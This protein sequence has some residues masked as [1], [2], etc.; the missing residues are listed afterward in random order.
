MGALGR[1]IED[2]GVPTTQISLI[3]LHTETIQPPRA[4]WVPFE[5][6]R[7]LGV[8]GDPEFQRRVL[9]S[10]LRL[11]EAPQGPVLEDYLEEAPASPD[12]PAVLSC[13]V[14]FTQDR[15]D[16]TDGEKLCSAL[17]KEMGA[18]RPWYDMALGKR[19][20]T[21]VGVSG[22]AL[23]AIPGF[24]C[25]FLG[26]DPPA[27]PLKDVKLPYALNLATD[28][29]KAFYFEAITSQPGQ[30]SVSGEGVSDWFYGETVA[31]RLMYKLREVCG[32]SEDKLMKVVGNVLIVPVGQAQRG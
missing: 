16:L 8:P 6:G 24:L 1:F 3:R 20:R 22:L 12:Q 14:D 28:D 7:P 2:E 18:M 11:L 10:V 9:L 15:T 32:K 21:T 5:L 19:G 29:L 23:D 25:A 30:E 13:P 26:G 4:L 17:R 31:G 27:S